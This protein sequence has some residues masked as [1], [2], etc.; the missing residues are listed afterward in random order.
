MTVHRGAIA[1]SCRL[2]LHFMALLGCTTGHLQ[3]A[4]ARNV[5]SVMRTG[6]PHCTLAKLQDKTAYQQLVESTSGTEQLAVITFSSERCRACAAMR[7]KLRSMSNGW[8]EVSWHVVELEQDDGNKALFKEI[9]IAKLPHVQIV[10]QGQAV[11]SYTCG[12]KR[13]ATVEDNLEVHGLE[14]RVRRRRMRRLALALQSLVRDNVDIVG[15][16][17]ALLAFCAMRPWRFVSLVP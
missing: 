16:M 14:R 12:P 13:L 2:M 17:A 15:P 11:E 8:P 10:R 5:P 3:L 7:P 4:S 9:G 1:R 6:A